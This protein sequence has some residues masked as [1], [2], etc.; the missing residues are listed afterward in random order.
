M[1]TPDPRPSSAAK[2]ARPWWVWPALVASVVLIAWLTLRP[3][4]DT[5]AQVAS[6]C[7]TCGAWVQDGLDN[8]ALFAP[9]GLLL[10]A[11]GARAWMV[12]LLA[13]A[14]STS[15]ELAQWEWIP[16]RY[17]TVGD[18]V[19][20]VL[21]AMSGAVAWRYRIWW[22]S[23]RAACISATLVGVTLAA[24]LSFATH[25]VRPAVPLGPFAAHLDPRRSPFALPAALQDARW[26][27]Q[28]LTCCPL[29]QAIRVAED[30]EREDATLMIR[31]SWEAA[32]DRRGRLLT[33]WDARSEAVVYLEVDR[34]EVSIR[35]A[36]IG[37]TW[38]LTSPR[39]A[40][41]WPTGVPGGREI[42]VMWT[43]QPGLQRL[44]VRQDGTSR[45]VEAVARPSLAGAILLPQR[46]PGGWIAQLAV[47]LAP[48]I[49]VGWWLGRTGRPV[50]VATVPF[51]V[52]L[53]AWC[54][55]SPSAAVGATTQDLLGVAVAMAV[56]GLFA[57]YLQRHE[58]A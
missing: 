10:A 2:A 53:G 15:I 22:P 42:E 19:A 23:R 52:A 47:W 6:R 29:P 38:G 4:G 24:A 41:P 9:F 11:T 51:L 12:F 39:L 14:G 44:R 21:G 3:S 5:A 30:L 48:A 40:V 28:R 49:V 20:N 13:L 25:A 32:I 58:G 33:V 26:N 55:R 56:S 35:V 34:D 31:A 54:G 16:G 17:A 37:G 57:L 45:E 27:G 18:V 1:L 36:S 7:A 50:A 8:I 43:V 46:P